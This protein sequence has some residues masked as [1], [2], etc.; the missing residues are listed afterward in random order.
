MYNHKVKLHFDVAF[1]IEN[2][3]KNG[4]SR[5]KSPTQRMRK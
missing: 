2:N 4:F 3:S 1:S 5:S